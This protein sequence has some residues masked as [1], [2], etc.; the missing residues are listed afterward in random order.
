MKIKLLLLCTSISFGLLAAK[1]PK[2]ASKET[3]EVVEKMID[4]HGGYDQWASIKT[5][6]FSNAMYSES[7]GLLRFWIHDQVVDMQNRRSYQDWPVVGSKLSFD[8]EQVWTENWRVGN[9][10]GH[11]QSV[12]F[13][14]L[15]LPWLTQDD[16]VMLS[17]TELITH[18][19]F[20]NDVYVVEM[21]YEKS[22]TVGKSAKDRY[23]LYIDSQTYLLVGYEYVIGY[24]PLLDVMGI[25]K[26]QEVFGPVF[27]KNNYFGDI[28]GLKFPLL[29]TTH[30]PE[31]TTQYGDHAVYD[32]R[33]D[34]EF[35]ESRMIAPPHAVVD[36][37][38][39][40]R[41]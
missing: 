15:N 31:L 21:G 28:N 16:H 6:S 35:D 19:A 17:D 22:P 23:K 7:L 37:A 10:P 26:E 12:F 5:L 1:G 2:Y 27:R 14:Y 29:F 20:D 41:K 33:I 38:V 13:Y 24:G 32:V 34:E 39:D 18:K 9:P 40:E 25:P 4:A 3:R 36:P 8:G 11:Q 30:D